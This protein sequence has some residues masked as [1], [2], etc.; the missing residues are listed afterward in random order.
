M[1]KLLLVV[2]LLTAINGYGFI[3]IGVDSEAVF[4]VSNPR[5]S[6]SC[7]T[8]SSVSIGVLTPSALLGRFKVSLGFKQ[9]L[10]KRVDNAKTFSCY[11]IFTRVNVPYSSFINIGVSKSSNENISAVNNNANRFGA[12]I[13]IGITCKNIDYEF[14]RLNSFIYGDKI[15]ISLFSVSY[16]IRLGGFIETN[17]N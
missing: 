7:S 10:N 4:E 2:M 17:K 8:N 13:G 16:K 6:S 9:Y 15:V 1:K 12:S 14:N 5:Y 11:N 3:I